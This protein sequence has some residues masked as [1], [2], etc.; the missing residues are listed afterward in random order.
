M[1]KYSLYLILCLF[2]FCVMTGCDTTD[3]EPK[4][5]PAATA[6]PQPSDIKTITIYSVD[7][8]SMM[9]IP[10]SV[11][12]DEQKLTARYISSLVLENLN[13]DSIIINQLEITEDTVILSFSS[14][15]RPIRKCE[16]VMEGLIL[17]S[18]ANSLLDNVE[19]CKKVIFRKDGGAYK[20]K[21]RSFKK[22]EVYA[23]E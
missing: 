17:D 5:T 20:S 22:N 1:K 10:V 21:Y 3:T 11:K 8:S 19:D 7:S 18:F 14:E 12:K 16:E 13:D 23:S 9:L 4:D 15:G 6:T 2:C